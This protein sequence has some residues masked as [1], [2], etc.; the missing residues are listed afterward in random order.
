[1][2]YGNISAGIGFDMM[3]KDYGN[4]TCKSSGEKIGLGGWYASGQS[5]A[6]LTGLIGINVSIF[7]VSQNIDILDVQTAALL[8]SQLPNPLYFSGKVGAGYSILNGLIKGKC[9]FEFSLGEKCNIAP[10]SV[11]DDIKVI[12]DVK[13]YNNEKNIDVY[14]TPEAAF[15]LKIGTFKMDNK[16]YRIELQTMSLYRSGKEVAGELT[17]NDDNTVFT[18][19][20]NEMLASNTEYELKVEVTFKELING[21]YVILKD[22]KGNQRREIET[23]KFTTDASV[24]QIPLS[25]VHYSFPVINQKNYYYNESSSAYIRLKQGHSAMFSDANS[26]YIARITKTDGNVLAEKTVTYNSSLYQIGWTMPTLAKSTKYKVSII[27]KAK[28]TANKVANIEDKTQYDDGETSVV[29][30]TKKLNAAAATA[31]EETII[32]YEFTTS[33][34][35]TLAEALSSLTFNSAKRNT[36]VAMDVNGKYYSIP[37]C[38]YLTM[39]ATTASAFDVADVTG[40]MYSNYTPLVKGKAKQESDFYTTDIYN[41]LYAHTTFD[42]L[43]DWGGRYNALVYSL[44]PLEAIEPVSSAPSKQFPW[45]YDLPIWYVNDTKYVN[46]QLVAKRSA[47]YDITKYE[48]LLYWLMPTISAY[49][50]RVDFTYQMPNGTMGTRATVTYDLK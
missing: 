46:T 18:R 35:G 44:M 7:G 9:N 24:K 36:L 4:R 20:P 41:H 19:T 3:L 30:E 34:V 29:Y 5:Y 10:I 47:G 31:N 25:K 43:V 11:L 14:S 8:E 50:Y 21:S 2:F 48:Y 1:M 12:A 6:Y 13:P 33:S 39:D 17:W 40:T 49:P 22:E 45:T 16:T 26:N 38:S 15:N 23:I 28:T 32:S 37:V 42:G 27:K